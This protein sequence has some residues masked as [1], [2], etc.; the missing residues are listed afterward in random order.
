[1]NVH[2][3]LLGAVWGAKPD[4]GWRIY[5]ISCGLRSQT[6]IGRVIDKQ[7]LDDIVREW[8]ERT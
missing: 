3:K 7:I 5:H 6:S 1:M 8:Y 2:V 4:D